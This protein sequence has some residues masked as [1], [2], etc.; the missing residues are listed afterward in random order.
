MSDTERQRHVD[1]LM[2]ARRDVAAA[3]RAGDEESEK[4]ARKRVHAAKV[5]LGERGPVWWDDGAP[6]Y[7]RKLL[8]NT[9]YGAVEE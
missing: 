2:D 6:D 9:P 3:K 8:E 7:T 1:A 4:A 5:T